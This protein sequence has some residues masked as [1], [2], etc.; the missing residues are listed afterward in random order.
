MK[1]EYSPFLL[2]FL[3]NCRP[4]DLPRHSESVVIAVNVANRD[5]VI[6]LLEKRLPSLK[7]SQAKRVEKTLKQIRALD[8]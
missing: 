3:S 8:A 4:K 5:A 2:G 7:T 6:A 1:R